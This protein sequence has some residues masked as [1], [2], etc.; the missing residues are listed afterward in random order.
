MIEQNGNKLSISFEDEVSSLSWGT[1][2][3]VIGGFAFLAYALRNFTPDIWLQSPGTFVFIG[4]ALTLILYPLWAQN[5]GLLSRV[6]LDGDRQTVVFHLQHS[7]RTSRTER[8]FSA[9]DRIVLA[10]IPASD[11][12]RARYLVDLDFGHDDRVMIFDSKDL[13]LSRDVWRR[14]GHFLRI[15]LPSLPL[16]DET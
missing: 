4:I 12:E 15:Y 14:V 9:L 11:T 5:K 13:P 6:E 2:L 1:P 16:A 10:V 7:Y 8:P 3:W